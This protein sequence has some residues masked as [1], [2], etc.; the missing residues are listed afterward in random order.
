MTRWVMAV[1]FVVGC[2]GS[3]GGHV[4]AHVGDAHV[5]GDA[6]DRD[7]PPACTITVHPCCGGALPLCIPVDGGACPAGTQL[8]QC[9]GNGGPTTGCAMTCTP[10]PPYC[11]PAGSSCAQE[12]GGSCG[13][14]TATDWECICA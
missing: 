9:F 14:Q 1:L 8:G 10:A 13:N 2:G 3:G 4:D 11:A 5:G 6:V 7:A 12:C